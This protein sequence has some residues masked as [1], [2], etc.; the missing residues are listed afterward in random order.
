MS[1]EDGWPGLCSAANAAVSGD[2]LRPR[3]A[4]AGNQAVKTDTPSGRPLTAALDS[5]SIIPEGTYVVK[6]INM[7]YLT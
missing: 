5:F 1:V 3:S 4:L 2:C 6:I 7:R